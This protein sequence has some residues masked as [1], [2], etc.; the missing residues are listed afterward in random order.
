MAS[1]EHAAIIARAIDQRKLR[2]QTVKAA[3]NPAAKFEARAK[4]D[5]KRRRDRDHMRKL[6]AA[7][8]SQKKS[9][10]AKPRQRK[11][12]TGWSGA[13]KPTQR[14][15]RV[16]SSKRCAKKASAKP[17]QRKARKSGRSA[18]KPTNRHIPV[19][20]CGRR[21]QDCACFTTGRGREIARSL[22]R[23]TFD[24]LPERVQKSRIQTWR[25]TG[26]MPGYM[27]QI[28]W[29]ASVRYSWLFP[30]AF[31]WRHFS[32]EEFWTA[33]QKVGAV[34]RN[35]QPNFCLIEKVMRA[36]A[37]AGVSCHGGLFYSGSV[38]T[39]YRFGNAAKPAQWQKCRADEDFI[40]REIM[41]LKVMGHVAG[42]LKKSFDNLQKE[43]SRQCWKACTEEFGKVLQQHTKGC[44]SGYSI[45]ITLDGVLLSQPCLESVVSW[46]PM[47]CTAYKR[48]LPE[49]YSECR[50]TQDDLFLAGCHLHQCLKASCP[51]FFLK[52]SLAQTCWLKR[53]VT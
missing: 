22:K 20:C 28:G 16:K 38:L 15:I 6:R 13:A 5:E 18:A 19:N 43:P 40:A 23:K 24:A 21:K 11:P 44:F 34:K 8:R 33:L 10:C 29:S 2:N 36:F 46:W 30:T 32:N 35:Q 9:K 48:K 12:G 7:R 39:E 17:R 52:D 26:D 45:K 1:R 53:K 3:K 42:K 50:G 47:Q 4:G 25:D 31:M 14:H 41:S 51:K 27:R 49:L 37:G